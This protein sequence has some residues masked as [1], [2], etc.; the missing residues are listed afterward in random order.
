MSFT[1]NFSSQ[2][3]TALA[4]RR[5]STRLLDATT[6]SAP[7]EIS[8]ARATASNYNEI[9]STAQTKGLVTA[10]LKDAYNILEAATD[11]LAQIASDLADIQVQTQ[12]GT[13]SVVTST[14]RT[15]DQASINASLADITAIVNNTKYKGTKLL[16]GNFSK[17]FQVGTSASEALNISIQGSSK[18]ALGLDSISIETIGDAIDSTTTVETAI[19]LVNS[20]LSEIA[21]KKLELSQYM[22][23]NSSSGITLS[24]TATKEKNLTIDFDSNEKKPSK[25]IDTS[26]LIGFLYGKTYSTKSKLSLKV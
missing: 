18:N 3:K 9:V 8:T 16:D 12:N 25:K 22:R 23:E 5:Y 2:Y 11:S 15:E 13:R 19:N 1:V 17:N 14:P 26:G 4:V 21:K 10:N 20:N 24:A 7:S 6:V